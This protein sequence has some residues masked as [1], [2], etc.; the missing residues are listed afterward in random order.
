[1]CW[2]GDIVYIIIIII[3]IINSIVP[4]GTYGVYQLPRTVV[5]SSFYPLL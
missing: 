2:P 3:I 1:M 4:L 5:H